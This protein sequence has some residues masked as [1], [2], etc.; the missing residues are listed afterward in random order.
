[1]NR[2]TT[3]DTFLATTKWSTARREALSQDAS[4][5]RYWRLR[6]DDQ[7]ALLMDAPPPEKPVSLFAKIARFLCEHGLHAPD[8]YAV[9]DAHGLMIV[10]DF[11]EDTFTRILAGDPEKQK[12]LYALA[13]DSLIKLH[14]IDSQALL[15]LADY[16]ANTLLEEAKL[17]TQWF[18]PAVSNKALS[19][20]QIEQFNAAWLHSF[21][22][23]KANQSVLVLRDYH[24]DNLM[25]VQLASGQSVCGLLDF[26][27]A[28][29]G[30]PAYDLMSLLED[31]RRDISAELKTHCLDRYFSALNA[32]N[33]LPNQ[34][35]LEP[36]FNVLAAQ[37]HAKVLGIFVRLYKRDAKAHYLNHLP[38]VLALYKAALWREPILSPLAEWMMDYLPFDEIDL[39]ILPTNMTT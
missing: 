5:R 20:T 29:I 26:Q 37:R 33:S 10:E 18:V 22:S 24:V 2:S 30:S 25:H 6:M 14:Q 34:T 8:I 19:A 3:I 32:R 23:I 39:A 9:D 16:D 28:L 12:Y 11:G 7:T 35:T 4:F 31:A 38:R 15:T 36:A 13:I 17:F 27:D 21:S 1:M